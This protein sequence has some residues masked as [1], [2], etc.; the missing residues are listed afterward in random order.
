MRRSVFGRHLYNQIAVPLVLAALAV[1]IVA[2]VVAVYFLSALTDQWVDHTAEATTAHLEERFNAVSSEMLSTARLISSDER[3]KRALLEGDLATARGI[4]AQ[5]SVILNADD[6]ILLDGSGMAVAASGRADIEPGDMVLATDQRSFTE[7]N[8]AYPILL[9]LDGAHTL[10][11]LQPI[12]V[13]DEVY[14][15]AV[16]NEV[17]D[18]FLDSLAG[19]AGEAYCLYDTDAQRVACSLTPGDLDQGAYDGLRS[20]LHDPGPEI[21]AALEA[22]ESGEPGVA[23]IDSGN[24][25]YRAWARRALPGR[26]PARQAGRLSRR[27]RESG[28]HGGGR[29]HDDPAHHHVVA[30]SD[31]VARR[32]GCV[33][34]SPCLRAARSILPR[35]PCAWPTGTSRRRSRSQ[36]P[37]RSRI[38]P[39]HSTR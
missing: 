13:G 26:R 33:G 8:M 3:L 20:E 31:T 17:N 9:E 16:S 35:A 28:G 11:A 30:H 19:G 5:A 24:G 15:V 12:S 7:I 4:V 38:S 22:A 29:A 2:T 32:S 23:T 37:T 25:T 10:T 14:T 39:V 36:E 18:T 21:L 1:G 6:V 34:G 27:Y